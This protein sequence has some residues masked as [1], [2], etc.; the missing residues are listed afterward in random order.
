M[1][2]DEARE[3]AINEMLVRFDAFV[4]R[5]HTRTGV[6]RLND[7]MLEGLLVA[8][9]ALDDIAAGRMRL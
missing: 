4:H 9:D 2:F 7:E 5:Q 1:A 6:E 8:K 3:T